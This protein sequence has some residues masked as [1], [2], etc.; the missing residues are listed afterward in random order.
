MIYSKSFCISGA[1]YKP[2]IFLNGSLFV[3]ELSCSSWF[4]VNSPVVPWKESVL[5][6]FVFLFVVFKYWGGKRHNT[7]DFL[8]MPFSLCKPSKTE[9]KFE[10]FDILHCYT[11]LL[12]KNIG[13]CKFWFLFC[14]NAAELFQMNCDC[15]CQHY[16]I[17]LNW[18]FTD[19]WYAKFI[20]PC[21][22]TNLVRCNSV[23][24]VGGAV[25]M[26]HYFNLESGLKYYLKTVQKHYYRVLNKINTLLRQKPPALVW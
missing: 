13:L 23:I 15:Y 24:N 8:H 2:Q 4:S 20:Q 26:L 5:Q 7:F 10:F 19:D 21:Y 6:E 3:T 16:F 17:S 25:A 9:Y 1:K 11:E 12:W 14:Q 22:C 18:H